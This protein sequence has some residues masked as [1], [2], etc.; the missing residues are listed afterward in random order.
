MVERSAR[1]AR[2]AINVWPERGN[3]TRDIHSLTRL[4][5]PYLCCSN[6][7]SNKPLAEVPPQ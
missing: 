6:V 1:G 4:C 7:P 2:G 5:V 3:D